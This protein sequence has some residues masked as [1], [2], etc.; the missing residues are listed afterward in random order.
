[1]RERDVTD[2][3][4][5][6]ARDWLAELGAS[7]CVIAKGERRCRL[8]APP[9]SRRG[10]RRGR[11]DGLV[12]A[13]IEGRTVT[14]TIES[15][16]AEGR[17]HLLPYQTAPGLAPG[18]RTAHAMDQAAAYPG[19]YRVLAVAAEAFES[20]PELERPVSEACAALGIGLWQV[21]GPQWVEELV[22]PRHVE[23]VVPHGDW[24][25]HYATEASLRKQ[26]AQVGESTSA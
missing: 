11:P 26:L 25:G 2:A 8:A 7:A 21:H 19:D 20:S 15:K 18:L 13:L 1:M 5:V 10:Q 14:L 24:L 6:H 22:A 16:S 9:G 12:V 17:R 4:V 23:L 3:A